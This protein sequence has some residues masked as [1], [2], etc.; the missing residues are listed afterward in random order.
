MARLYEIGQTVKNYLILDYDYSGKTMKYKCKCLN[1]GEIKSIYGGS[2]SVAKGIGCRKCMG[3]HYIHTEFIGQKFGCYTVIGIGERR[4]YRNELTYV[5]RCDCG[6]EISL[7]KTQL[8]REEHIGLIDQMMKLERPF[9]CPHG[10]PTAYEISKYE[11]E[12]RF[13]RK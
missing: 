2:L 7:T 4:A 8:T 6:N 3:E 1:C 10:R 13:A 9:T 11:I 12:R 5:C